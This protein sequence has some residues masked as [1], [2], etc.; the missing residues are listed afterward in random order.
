MRATWAILAG[1]LTLLVGQRTSSADRPPDV[2]LRVGTDA[3]TASLGCVRRAGAAL[4][5]HSRGGAHVTDG[6][7]VSVFNACIDDDGQINPSEAMLIAN[8]RGLSTQTADRYRLIYLSNQI[9]VSRAGF[10]FVDGAKEMDASLVMNKALPMPNGWKPGPATLRTYVDETE[11]LGP[12]MTD[13]FLE[14]EFENLAGELSRE[15]P[16][17]TMTVAAPTRSGADV[18][19]ARVSLSFGTTV[20]LWTYPSMQDA[21]RAWQAK[22]AAMRHGGAS[23]QLMQQGTQVWRGT[24]RDDYWLKHLTLTPAT[25]KVIKTTGVDL[26]ARGRH[27]EDRLLER[28]RKQLKAAGQKVDYSMKGLEKALDRIGL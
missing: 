23:A 5:D 16:S 10:A 27:Y 25:Q 9:T 3:W 21:K 15:W 8:L 13:Q 2:V 26:R 22:A 12:L 28:Y 17:S 4:R 1:L 19:Y 6:E 11:P 24:A 7:L 18:W 20:E 14:M